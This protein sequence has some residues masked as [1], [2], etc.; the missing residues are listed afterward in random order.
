MGLRVLNYRKPTSNN[1]LLH[2]ESLHL[3]SLKKSI[4]GAQ[5]F[6]VCRDC[7]SLADFEKEAGELKKRFFKCEY[8]KQWINRAYERARKVR[9]YGIV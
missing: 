6:K 7:A 2:A 4:L 8:K 9:T 1:N 5:Y 3:E